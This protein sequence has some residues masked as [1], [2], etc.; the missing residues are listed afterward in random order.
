MIASKRRQGTLFCSRATGILS[1]NAKLDTKLVLVAGVILAAVVGFAVFRPTLPT[2]SVMSKPLVTR[3]LGERLFSSKTS[4]ES[5][6]SKM[7]SRSDLRRLMVTSLDRQPLASLSSICAPP[8]L[9][10]H[11]QIAFLRRHISLNSSYVKDNNKAL[12]GLE[13]WVEW[14]EF[15][16]K[17][18]LPTYQI[19]TVEIHDIFVMAGL[20][21]RYNK[22]KSTKEVA[23]TWNNREHRAQFTWQQLLTVDP[24]LAYRAWTMAH[25]YGYTY[26]VEFAD[27]TCLESTPTC[28]PDGGTLEANARCPPGSK[29][30]LQIADFGTTTEPV[31]IENGWISRGCIEVEIAG[32]QFGIPGEEFLRSRDLLETCTPRDDKIICA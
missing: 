17:L 28:D 16:D 27:L 31:E 10:R 25:R 22:T 20:D 12:L 6:W 32:M 26:D 2:R 11:E 24:D 19:E 14:H 8:E 21:H 15:L 18:N 7:K 13:F 9:D 30:Q 5:S 23:K 4:Y 29:P 3:G 1:G